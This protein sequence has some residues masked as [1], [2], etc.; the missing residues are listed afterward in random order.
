MR[1]H[2]RYVDNKLHRLNAS[3]YNNT[4]QVTLDPMGEVHLLCAC[5]ATCGRGSSSR[6]AHGS[7][8]DA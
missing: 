1:D 4:M 7:T 8:T 6:L 2:A 5:D 3:N